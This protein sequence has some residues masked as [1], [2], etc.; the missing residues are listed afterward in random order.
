[1]HVCL[2]KNDQLADLVYKKDITLSLTL[3]YNPQNILTFNDRFSGIEMYALFGFLN[4]S[5]ILLRE[6]N[7]TAP[8]R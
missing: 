4:A 8:L 5:A 7:N 3:H 1:M 2:M 6:P